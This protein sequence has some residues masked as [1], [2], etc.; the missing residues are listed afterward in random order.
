MTGEPTDDESL[1]P[2]SSLSYIFDSRPDESPQRATECHM[3]NF[4]TSEQLADLGSRCESS[5]G[6]V[7]RK[8]RETDRPRVMAQRSTDL[9]MH[10][11]AT[12]DTARTAAAAVRVDA[13]NDQPQPILKIRNNRQPREQMTR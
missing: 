11:A 1:R 7:S 4:G 2:S 9:A 6:C 13:S 8:K 5:R 12:N 3:L 10:H